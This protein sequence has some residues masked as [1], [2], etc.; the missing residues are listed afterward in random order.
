MCF[1]I[2]EW[3]LLLSNI[4]VLVVNCILIVDD[5]TAELSIIMSTETNNS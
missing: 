5:S 1:D 2:S 3:A 4:V